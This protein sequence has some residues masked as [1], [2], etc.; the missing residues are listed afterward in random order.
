MGRL[1]LL[2]ECALLQSSDVIP[3]R[4]INTYQFMMSACQNHTTVHRQMQVNSPM[5]LLEDNANFNP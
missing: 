1:A 5:L 3:A 2:F 4:Q